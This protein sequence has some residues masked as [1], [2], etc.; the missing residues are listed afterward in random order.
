MIE[1]AWD[2]GTL[3][4]ELKQETF[5]KYDAFTVGGVFHMQPA[6][7][8]A[9][10]GE[11]GYFSTMFDLSA[12]KLTCG[13]H[14]WYDAKPFPS[15]A[16]EKPSL[17]P[18]G[19]LANIIENHDEPRGAS[20]FLPDYVQ[21]EAGK[22]ML[23]TTSLLLRGIPFLYQGQELGI[24]NCRRS[25]IDEYND[26]NT[27]DQY[28]LALDSGCSQS[29]ALQSCWE[30]SRD[31]ART[32]MQWSAAEHAGFSTGKPWLVV[33]P[34]YKKINAA[35]Q[36]TRKDSVLQYYRRLIAL[37]KAPAYVDTF[38]YGDFIPAFE[39]KYHILAYWHIN[40]ENRQKI[41]ATANYGTEA[42]SLPLPAGEYELLLS[43][44]DISVEKVLY[45]PNCAAAV[46]LWKGIS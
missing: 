2:I 38:V 34:N 24:T 3:L 17:L 37:R 27:L 28:Q 5:A 14:G 35:E 18:I 30:N 31:N 22:K 20:R 4:Q 21:N 7:L 40:P 41:L 33:N 11:N 16:G 19:F 39:T 9:F 29:Q 36:E 43:N 26:I 8:Q 6:E 10:V 44:M 13:E 32:P 46:L 15:T 12:Q 23:E 45:L 25:S 1:Q 42:Q